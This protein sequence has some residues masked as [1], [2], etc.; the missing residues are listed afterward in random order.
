MTAVNICNQA[1]SLV[2]ARAEIVTLGDASKEAKVCNLWYDNAR[3]T[4]LR[5]AHW[6]FARKQ[7]ALVAVPDAA[8][9]T[10]IDPWQYIYTYPTDCLKLRYTFTPGPAASNATIPPTEALQGWGQ[11]SRANRFLL[12]TYLTNAMSPVMHKGILSNVASAIG[13]Y[14]ADITN[15]DLFDPLF[16]DALVNALAA[17]MVIP[18]T[19]N[20]G[21]KSTFEQLATMA[22]NQARAVDGNEAM[23]STEHIPDWIA[24]RGAIGSPYYCGPNIGSWYGA[25]D[26]LP[27]G[28]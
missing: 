9:T 13:V 18:M 11:A 4:L 10:S 25:W 14:T 17:I 21:M 5:C 26:S 24:T 3:Q 19:G 8:T 1:L 6:G 27:W 15:V 20:A 2:G 7:A 22:I 12:T 28:E 23:P 16:E